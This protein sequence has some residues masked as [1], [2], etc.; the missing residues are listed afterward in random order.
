[1][2]VA[3]ICGAASEPSMAGALPV[4]RHPP[5]ACS[6]CGC[7]AA[8]STSPTRISVLFSGR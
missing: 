5:N 4:A 1:M 6:I 7:M 2:V 8:A 3:P